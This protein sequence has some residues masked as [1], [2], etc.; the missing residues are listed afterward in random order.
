MTTT[1]SGESALVCVGLQ[2]TRFYLKKLAKRHGQQSAEGVGSVMDWGLGACENNMEGQEEWRVPGR[3][4]SG[5]AALPG[6]W[7]LVDGFRGAGQRW[8][9][10]RW[11]D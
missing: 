1:G 5:M 8:K 7:R 11:A 3:E 10:Q 4:Q 9:G 2:F 6:S